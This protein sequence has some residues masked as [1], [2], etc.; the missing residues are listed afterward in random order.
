MNIIMYFSLERQHYIT[1]HPLRIFRHHWSLFFN[2]YFLIYLFVY[3]DVPGG[4]NLKFG[5]RFRNEVEFEF[6]LEGFF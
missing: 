2:V 6:N 4:L 1:F 3:L 5:L